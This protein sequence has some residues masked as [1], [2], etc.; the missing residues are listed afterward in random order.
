MSMSD[1]LPKRPKDHERRQYQWYVDYDRGDEYDKHPP[2]SSDM[3]T[4]VVESDED[5]G[6]KSLRIYDKYDPEH[7]WIRSDIVFDLVGAR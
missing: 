3:G 2:W 5:F 7:I 4:D 6:P 1:D